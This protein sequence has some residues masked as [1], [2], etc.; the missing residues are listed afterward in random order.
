MNR[1]FHLLSLVLNVLWKIKRS[2]TS[3]QCLSQQPRERLCFLP[4]LTGVGLESTQPSPGSSA[5]TYSL[6]CS[7]P[8]KTHIDR[9]N[10]CY[11][12][13][14]HAKGVGGSCIQAVD[15]CNDR[16]PLSYYEMIR[17]WIQN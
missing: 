7:I 10:F 3:R 6:G 13:N 8:F 2:V 5:S 1:D 15:S 16:E 12:Y 4:S 9:D 17:K 14:C 11:N